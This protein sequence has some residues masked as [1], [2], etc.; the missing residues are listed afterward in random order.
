MRFRR[1]CC[2]RLTSLASRWFTRFGHPRF[3]RQPD[4]ER[5]SLGEALLTSIRVGRVA[6]IAASRR[7]RP[8]RGSSP[9]SRT[10]AGA[11]A[12]IV[13]E[14]DALMIFDRCGTLIVEHPGWGG[15]HHGA[16]P[17]SGHH[18]PP[19]FPTTVV[20]EYEGGEKK[21]RW[22]S[23]GAEVTPERPATAAT[24]RTTRSPCR[25]GRANWPQ[26]RLRAGLYISSA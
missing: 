22:L 18:P 13:E 20:C 6:A 15:D 19:L 3:S 21:G 7:P 16:L 9:T 2:N 8:L 1:S 14:S 17:G 11:T 10:L 4:G 25:I 26:I 12:Y 5:I 23:D 24:P